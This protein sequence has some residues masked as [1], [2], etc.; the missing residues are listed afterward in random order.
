MNFGSVS[1]TMKEMLCCH[2]A[3]RRL[4]FAAEDIFAFYASI[5]T[6]PK[7]V[8]GVELRAQGKSFA[9]SCGVTDLEPQ[10]FAD[11]WTNLVNA[12]N[13]KEIGDDE[14]DQCWASSM[15]YDRWPYLITALAERGFKFPAGFLFSTRPSSLTH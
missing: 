11:T 1:D 14:M 12:F 8:G 5:E 4:G 10:V 2:E 15:I 9:L 13:T 3:L 6:T 7:K